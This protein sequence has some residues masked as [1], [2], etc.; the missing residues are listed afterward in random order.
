MK[1]TDIVLA[2]LVITVALV[3]MPGM[4]AEHSPPENALSVEYIQTPSL[5]ET[6]FEIQDVPKRKQC[7]IDILLPLVLKANSKVLQMRRSLEHIKNTPLW[8]TEKEKRLIEKLAEEYRVEPGSYKDMVDEL[9][10]RVDVLPASLMLAQAA[11]ESGWG[12]SRFVR[13]GNN[14]FGL[15][16]LSGYG[17]VPKERSQGKSF[18]VSRFKDLQASI[19]FYLWTINTH[20]KY[21]E[22]RKIRSTS[23]YPY[24]PVVIAE[25]LRHYSE[26]GDEYVETIVNL[27]DYNNLRQYDFYTLR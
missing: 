2:V 4:V 8:L 1:N 12:T 3:V 14:L 5:P 17:M 18:K 20:K 16:S 13:E 21:E 24:D 27:M 10:I 26:K 22:L 15:R 6:F 25:G 23:P 7:L 11:V 19:D 9:L